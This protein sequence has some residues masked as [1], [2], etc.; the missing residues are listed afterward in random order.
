MDTD[1]MAHGSTECTTEDEYEREL[2][3]HKIEVPASDFYEDLDEDPDF[4]TVM[5]VI[6]LDKAPRVNREDG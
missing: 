3:K 1:P 6:S 5:E 4:I 2:D